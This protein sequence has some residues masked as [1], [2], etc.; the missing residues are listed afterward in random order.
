MTRLFAVGEEWLMK[1]RYCSVSDDLNILRNLTL[2]DLSN[3]MKKYSFENPFTVAV[4]KMD[5]LRDYV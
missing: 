3:V 4:G 2:D 5:S 1:R